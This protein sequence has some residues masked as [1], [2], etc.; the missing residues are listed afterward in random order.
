[1]TPPIHPRDSQTATAVW[2]LFLIGLAAATLTF[3]LALLGAI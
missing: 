2:Y 3:I 1:M